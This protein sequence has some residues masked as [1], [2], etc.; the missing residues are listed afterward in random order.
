MQT[1]YINNLN[2]LPDLEQNSCAIGNFDGLHVGHRDLI[3]KA[4]NLYETNFFEAVEPDLMFNKIFYNSRIIIFYRSAHFP[5][6]DEKEKF[7]RIINCVIN[8]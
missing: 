1:F 2:N 3:E 7:I 5:F 4:K 8:E 6:L